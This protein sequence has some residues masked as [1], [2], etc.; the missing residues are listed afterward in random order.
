MPPM[1]KNFLPHIITFFG[2]VLIFAGCQSQPQESA[3]QTTSLSTFSTPK[4][5]STGGEEIMADAIRNGTSATCQIKE[6]QEDSPMTAWIEG[7]KMR[8]DGVET[9]KGKTNGTVLNDGTYV[10]LWENDKTTGMKSELPRPEEMAWVLDQVR[11]NG[12]NV[13]DAT[14]PERVHIL[15]REGYNFNCQKVEVIDNQLFTPP[16][17]ITFN[18]MSAVMNSAVQWMRE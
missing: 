1:P 8:L 15:A 3:D 9:D 13:P 6:T 16:Q 10:Y 17:E 5:L 7:N 4:V 14:T 11:K 12:M 18:D 2:C